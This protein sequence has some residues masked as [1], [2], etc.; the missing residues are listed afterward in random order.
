MTLEELLAQ[1]RES[2]VRHGLD[3]DKTQAHPDG[4]CVFYELCDNRKTTDV[5]CFASLQFD[6]CQHTVLAQCSHASERNEF[7]NVDEAMADVALFAK[8][9]VVTP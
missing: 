3:P 6:G 5:W 4:L 9:H 1:V 8:T 2:A 7:D